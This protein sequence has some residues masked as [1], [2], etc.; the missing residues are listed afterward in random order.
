MIPIGENGLFYRE[1]TDMSEGKRHR[2]QYFTRCDEIV[3]MS[4]RFPLLGGEEGHR[5]TIS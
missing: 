1:R 2:T 5:T 3:P 4:F